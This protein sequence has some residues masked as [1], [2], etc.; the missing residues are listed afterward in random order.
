M[1][2]VSFEHLIIIKKNGASRHSNLRLNHCTDLYLQQI[3]LFLPSVTDI[4][5]IEKGNDHFPAKKTTRTVVIMSYDLMV[6]KRN[7]I[8]EYGFKAIIFVSSSLNHG[9]Y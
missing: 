8:N 1:G 3:E 5:I 7:H 9:I 2:T 4:S 6:S